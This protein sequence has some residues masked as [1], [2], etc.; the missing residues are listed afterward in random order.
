MFTGIYFAS[1]KASKGI[2][3]SQNEM[4]LLKLNLFVIQVGQ[5]R[6]ILVCT[7]LLTEFLQIL[8]EGV[9]ELV[10]REHLDQRIFPV[11]FVFFGL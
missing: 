7:F 8:K 10:I 4:K 11:L 5:P 1:F 6:I 9:N 3:V 2:L